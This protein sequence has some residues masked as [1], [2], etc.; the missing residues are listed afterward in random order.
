MAPV[1]SF[2]PPHALYS[3]HA[4]SSFRELAVPPQAKPATVDVPSLQNAS[5]VLHDQFVKDAQTIPEVGDLLATPGGQSSASYSVYPDD[6]RVPFQRRRLVGIPEALFQ[7]YNTTNVTSHMGLIPEIER[8]WVAIDHKLFLWDYMEGQEISSFVD[9]PDV[10]THV[11]VVK[12]KQGVF[13]DDITS[14]MVICTPVSILLIGLS[15]NSVTGLNSRSHKDIKMYATDMS[16]SSDVEMT[17]VAGTSDGRVF[18]C[19]SQDGCLYEL[20]Y[21]QNESWF[22]KRV[23]LINHSV[24]SMQSLLPRFT[25]P[26]PE[27]RTT[28]IV[29]DPSRGIIYALSAKNAISIYRP[30]GDKAV[31]HLQTISNLLKLAQEKAPGSGAVTPANFHVI[32]LLPIPSTESRSSVQLVAITSAG[33]RL[34]FSASTSYGY[35]SASTSLSSPRPLTL[36][37]V[38]LP[39]SNL[40]HPDEQS[41]PHRPTAIVTYGAPQNPSTSRPY[42]ISGLEHSCYMDALTVSAQP[43]DTDGTDFLLCTSPDLTRIG[44]FGQLQHQAPSQQAPYGGPTYV[45]NTNQRPPLTENATLL[46]IPGRTWAMAPV[47]QISQTFGSSA[48]SPAVANELAFQFSEHPRQFMIL[49]NVGIT[50]LVKRRAVDCLRAILEEVR[51]DGAVQPL[52]EFRDSYGRDQTCAM[53]LALACGN[54]YL[55]ISDQSMG[56]L[57]TVSSDLASVAKQAFYDFGER[58]IW[59]ER[60]TYGT[61]ESSGTAIFSGRRE[62][63]ALYFARLVRP[64][65]KEKLTTSRSTGLQ[66]L[67]VSESVLVTTQKNMIALKDFLDQNPHLFH[68]SPGDLTV[69]R[70]PAGNEQEAWK[71]EQTSVAQ[72]VLLLTRSI[73]AISFVLLLNDYNLGELISQCEEGSRTRITSMTFEELA[74]AQDSVAVSRALI[75]VIIDQQI[76][77]QLSVDT[78]SEVLQQRCGSFCST[79][80]VM[81]YKARENVRK[82]IESR[83]PTEW[84]T[85]LGESLRLFTKGARTLDLPK[86][87][88]ICND[89]RQLGYAKGVIE[90]PLICAQ[91]QDADNL[92][93]DYWLAGCPSN[94]PRSELYQRREQCYRL[95]LHSLEV[96]EK[97]ATAGESSGSKEDPETSKN[98][99]Y[100]LAFASEDEMFHSTLYDWLIERGLVDELLTMRPPFLEAHLKREP[101]TVQKY[102]LLWQFYVKDG[103]PLR[104]AEV[105][106]ILAESPSDDLTLSARLEYL[107]LAVGN[108]KSHPITVGNKHET[109]IA[110][111]TDLEEKLDVAQVQLEIYQTLLPHAHDPGEAGEQIRLLDKGL[112]TITE[113]YQMYAE[114]FDLPVMKLLILHVS[115]HRDEHIVLPIWNRIF[116]DAVEAGA[117]GQTN[118]DHIITGVVPL[119]QR[120]YPSESAFPLRHVAALLVKFSLAQKGALPHGWTPRVLV[121]CSVPYTEIWEVLHEMYESHIPP[122]NEQASV[123][124]IS[125]DIA[126]LFND[127]LEEARRPQSS[128]AR[129]EFPV[130][131]ID[132]AIDQYLSELE[133]SRTETKT[134]YENVKRQLRRNW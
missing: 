9:Q 128:I 100:E 36:V 7:Y 54:T 105:L 10:I 79:D 5:R 112:L 130:G 4:A 109:A 21:Q 59:T 69:A 108:A 134:A 82:A 110:F 49:T 86:V 120:F 56:L 25:S 73:E 14:V 75:N 33:V 3:S 101:T 11:A 90:F 74:T 45:T 18:M 20:H 93:F 76:G 17:S 64:F 28:S 58:P 121:Q 94:D 40:L 23:Q 89:Y 85:W 61:A 22:G 111:L 47:P 66:H 35:S 50:F 104:A 88:E 125:S 6:Y 77:Q 78:V 127:W 46:S 99:A 15:I 37:H 133:P 27:D 80:D 124:A 57:Q 83:T 31:H 32:T 60:V 26:R 123:Q 103:Q 102:Q 126:V 2:T 91:V 38:R 44:S 8:A 62:G 43:G 68:S 84:Q 115:E 92:G 53:L 1:P 131:R 30:S 42:P 51:T 41:N 98:H 114:T 107:T 132:L 16:V 67:N 87:E 72:L 29:S 122:F 106:A 119:G 52:I 39:P 63:L 118:A 113:L 95:I 24:G 81:L 12:P 34:Y 96:F 116:E 70:T 97:R 129:R 19:S 117:D 13:I 55:D 48:P 71:A 65:W